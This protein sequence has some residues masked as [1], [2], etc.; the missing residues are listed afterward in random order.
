[1]FGSLFGRSKQKQ[2]FRDTIDV[3]N[4]LYLLTFTTSKYP[5]EIQKFDQ[6]G[7]KFNEHE[8]AIIFLASYSSHIKRDHP[9]AEIEVKKYISRAKG[10]YDRGLARDPMPREY[11]FSVVSERFGI[12]PNAVPAK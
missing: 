11:L 8:I 9:Q 3:L 7:D 5:S 1:M 2:K 4:K 6:A 12:D 10:A